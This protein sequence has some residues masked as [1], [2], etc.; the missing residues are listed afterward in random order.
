MDGV[1]LLFDESA[2]LISIADIAASARFSER[3]SAAA[4]RRAMSALRPTLRCN[5]KASANYSMLAELLLAQ[6]GRPLVLVVGGKELGAGLGSLAARTEIELIESD[7]LPGSRVGLIC[8]AHRLPLRPA[9]V[10]AV[11]I[12]A[13]LDDVMDPHGCVDEIVRVLKPNGLVYAETPFLQAVHDPPFD[14]TRFTR[15][16]H[17]LLFRHFAELDS[18]TT[19]GPAQALAGMYHAFLM[20]FARGRL[21]RA[22]ASLFARCTAFW[23]KYVD[24]WLL[25]DNDDATA[26]SGYYFLGRRSETALS[27]RDLVGAHR[28]AERIWLSHM[29]VQ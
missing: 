11:V 21:G 5:R 25:D 9:S 19:G 3:S 2:S 27:D 15:S 14:F 1:P 8:D 26:A 7:I 12:Q 13:V 29:I 28:A 6:E 24:F 18:G 17:R 23:L 22:A 4:W 20:S 10:D 16:G